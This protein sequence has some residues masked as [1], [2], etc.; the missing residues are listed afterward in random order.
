[1]GGRSADSGRDPTDIGLRLR[2]G[3]GRHCC[4]FAIGKGIVL[5]QGHG[6]MLLP[7]KVEIAPWMLLLP[8]RKKQPKFR[9]SVCEEQIGAH[10]S[11]WAE[12]YPDRNGQ[13]AGFCPCFAGD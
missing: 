10:A 4:S 8:S 5:Q 1:M 3:Y 2:E 6:Q 12:L 11:A 13:D 9:L 7:R